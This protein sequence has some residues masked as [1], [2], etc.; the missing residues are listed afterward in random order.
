MPNYLAD[1]GYLA[2][3]PE[4]TEGEAKQPKHF[5]PL[6]SE[7]IRIDL[8][9]VADRRMKGVAWKSDDLLRGS[10]NH[11][12]PVVVLAD[13]DNLGHLLNMCFKKGATSGSASNGW[14]HPFTV[15]APKSY[16]IEIGKGGYAQRYTGAKGENLKLE[17]VDGKLQATLDIA[18]MKQFSVA[19]LAED[20]SGSTTFFTLKQ[21]YDLNP[22]DGLAVDDVITVGGVDATITEIDANGIKVTFS[23]VEI[24]ASIGDPV[25]LKAQTP[26]FGSLVEPFYQGNALVG[27]EGTE[28][29]A[30]ASAASKTLATPIYELTLDKIANLMK[31][32]ASGSMDPIKI[33]PGMQEAKL[34][35]SQL[36]EN[37]QQ[38]QSW[39][40]RTKQAI[41][42]IISG[43]AIGTALEKLTMIFPNVKLLTN[44][45][46]LDV[47][48]YIFDK[49]DFEVLMGNTF[50]IN[51]ELVNRSASTMFV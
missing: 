35:I 47:G 20:L 11:E 43:K 32:P 2:V 7:G 9:H 21:D 24:E 37:E 8:A 19:T 39:L 18:A 16:T 1:L 22:T 26:S 38:H 25:K 15:G 44:E 27:I 33:L 5:I 42:A 29:S 4:D 3:I 30:T 28:A 14:I 31:A 36:F 6:V 10:R 34:T 23:E 51:V 50:A 46:P 17:F 49:Q 48:E 40:D 13:P 41:T 12:G 45:E